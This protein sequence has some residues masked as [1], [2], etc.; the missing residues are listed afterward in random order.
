MH[1]GDADAEH[2]AAELR[3]KRSAL[4]ADAEGHGA[5]KDCKDQG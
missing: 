5:G 3:G 4:R 2:G 1:S